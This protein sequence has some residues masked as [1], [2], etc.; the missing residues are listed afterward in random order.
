MVR[1]LLEL[2]EETNQK[3]NLIKAQYRLSDKSEAVSFAIRHFKDP[4]SQP[5]FNYSFDG[6]Q[7]MLGE[8]IPDIDFFFS[9][10]WLSCFVDEF[11]YPSG[12]AY[13]KILAVYEG[14]HLLFYFGKEDSLAVGKNILDKFL[15]N[16][17]F[18]E[19]TNNKIQEYSEKLMSY[20]KTIPD[21]NLS[22]LTNH[23]LW[24]IYEKQ[25]R[26]HT[27]YYQWGWIP[28]AVD[29]FHSNF[30]DALKNHLKALGVSEEKV[31]EYFL[32]LTHPQKKSLIQIEQEEFLELALK[33]STDKIHVKLF[34]DLYRNFKEKEVA[35]FGYKTHTLE[36]EELLEN[37][38]A[39]LVSKIKL[40]YYKEIKAH[41]E[42][43]FYINHMWVG[44]TFTFEHYLKEVVKLIGTHANI[45][46]ML[47]DVQAE[48]ELAKEKRKK[49]LKEI[50][51]E[52]K[53][54]IL[55]DAFGDFMVTKISRRFAQIY[56]MYKME[57]I[58]SEI[59][60]RFE[61]KLLDVR[62][63]LPSEVKEALV[64][65]NINK[66]ILKERSEFC[67]YYAQK[68]VDVVYTGQKAR[69]LAESAKKIEIGEVNEIKGQVACLGKATGHVKIII[70]PSDMAKMQQG[71]ILVSIATD[72]DIV[73][74]MK[75]AAA[76]VTEQGGVTS[77]AAIVSREMGTPCVIGTKI[78]TKVFKDGDLVEVDA[79]KGIV[80]KISK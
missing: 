24:E 16:P 7:W 12:R 27:E 43:Y 17:A 51:I 77:H 29:M 71:D 45:K 62:F 36:Y 60:K 26:I 42:K 2:D 39:E 76:I 25:D 46:Q 4:E 55:F 22:S 8:D 19:E 78:A 33:I 66:E 38:T 28:V 64:N 34:E 23:K 9:Q 21:T 49:V 56:A 35:K 54:I 74:A 69:E 20:C 37:K 61:L 10:M 63:L 44:K 15:E 30:T 47:A 58:L 57:F 14:Y 48:A 70:R 59:A 52:K 11:A 3:I 13:K 67:V 79:V 40:E 5:K 1:A 32:A 68:G 80:K 65:G 72:P 41:Y 18:A 6:D 73:P 53:W 31:S 75:K 50:K